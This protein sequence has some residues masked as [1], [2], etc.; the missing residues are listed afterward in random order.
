VVGEIPMVLACQQAGHQAL[1]PMQNASYGRQVPDAKVIGAEHLLQVHAYLQHQQKLP[2]PTPLPAPDH[3]QWLDLQ[4]VQGQAHA[5]RVLE[6]AASG[7]HH[8]LMFG[9]A[10]TG[11]SMLAQR[12]PGLLP[13]LSRAESLECAAIYSVAGL[14]SANQLWQQRPFRQPHHS[15]SAIALVGGGSLPK[16]GE[17][18]LA[19]HGTLFLDELP[20]FPRA[21][22]EVLRQPLEE[23][24][25]HIS[26]AA[27][28]AEF[29]AQFQ[30]I[31]ALNP[32]PSGHHQDGRSS[33]E[34]IRRYLGRLSGPLLD[35]IDLQVEVP[36]LPLSQL[37]QS[38]AGESSQ[39]VRQ[40]VLKAHQRQWQRQGKSN[41]RLTPFELEQYCQLSEPDQR[42]LY[43]CL[44]QLAMSARNF[45][46][47]LR[48]SRT[49]AD[50]AESDTIQ[51]PH[52]LEA[53][54][55]RSFDRLLKNLYQD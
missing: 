33:K 44:E 10:G 35:R 17:I 4:D 21:V 24:V 36:L 16:P 14:P 53:L 50:L 39:Q 51:R 11:K 22:L 41:A 15:C 47:L 49:I 48:V 1:M 7:R 54:S 55:Y 26:R 34:Q 30:L 13:P 42:Y 37:Q 32:S 43:Q 19:H 6:I 9:P 52:L 46:K 5:K 18:S 20:E 45:H 38:R 40:R 29:P 31:A 3:H 8:L 27:R 12:L 2:D 23:G 28:Q 25:V